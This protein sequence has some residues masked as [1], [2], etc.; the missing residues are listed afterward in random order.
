MSVV[1][2]HG[3]K[4]PPPGLVYVGRRMGDHWP[5]SP[6]GNPYHLPRNHTPQ[7]RVKAVE[8]YAKWL[9]ERLADT[10]SPQAIELDRLRALAEAGPLALGCWCAPALCHGHVLEYLLLKQLGQ[11]TAQTTWAKHLAG[12]VPEQMALIET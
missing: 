6:L 8:D 10:A 3:M 4:A 9:S 5:E 11:D 2:V 7:Q 1:N 12:T